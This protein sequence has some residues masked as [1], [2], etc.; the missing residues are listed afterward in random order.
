MEIV[1]HHN[2]SGRWMG[3]PKDREDIIAS[4]ETYDEMMDN[5]KEIYTAVIE[6][7]QK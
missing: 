7:E 5:I 6:Y 4:G 3:W 1:F 2:E